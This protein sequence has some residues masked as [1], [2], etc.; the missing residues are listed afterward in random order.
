LP[1]RFAVQGAVLAPFTNSTH[2]AE[3]DAVDA[4]ERSGRPYLQTRARVRWGALDDG[5]LSDGEMLSHGGE[6][7]VSSHFGWARL[8]GTTLKQSKAIAADARFALPGRL[9]FRGEVYSGQLLRGLGGGAIAQT[10]GRPIDSTTVGPI[11]R[12]VAG[13]FQLNAQ[14]SPIFIAGVGCGL[15]VVNLRDRP[16]RERNGNCAAHALLRPGQPVFIGFEVRG[17]QTR[18]S[19]RN[20]RGTHLNLVMGFEL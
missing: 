3:P 9:E 15:D 5:S 7:G 16:V 19:G 10:F 17:M 1:L 18:Y 11:L 6:I 4:G 14:L 13:W 2:V 20:F 8:S 12:D